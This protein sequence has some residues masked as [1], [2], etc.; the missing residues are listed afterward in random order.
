MGQL[1]EKGDRGESRHGKQRDDFYSKRYKEGRQIPAFFK[2]IRDRQHRSDSDGLGGKEK[3]I[4]DTYGKIW[5]DGKCT[6]RKGRPVRAFLKF[7]TL[8]VGHLLCPFLLYCREIT[9]CTVQE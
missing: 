9:L 2:D 3:E 7:S 5:R 8:R 4:G 1:Q 6:E